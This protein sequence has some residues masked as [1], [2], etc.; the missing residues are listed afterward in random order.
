VKMDSY[1]DWVRSCYYI[2]A[3][4]NPAISVPCGFTDDG[5]PVGMQLVGRNRGEFDLLQIAHAFEQATNFG[6]HRP[7]IAL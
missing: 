6:L 1:I 3:T 7:P 4:T 2:S 5:L